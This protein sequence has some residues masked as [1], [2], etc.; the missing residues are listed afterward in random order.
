MISGYVG[1][2]D[3][4]DDAMARFAFA[5]ADQTE[6]DHAALVAAAK[7]GRIKVAEAEAED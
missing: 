3:E 4:L 1:N 2:S 7:S 5:Y 6:K